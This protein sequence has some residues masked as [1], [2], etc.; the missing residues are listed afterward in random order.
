MSVSNG[1]TNENIVL[2]P[3]LS[4]IENHTI[5]MKNVGYNGDFIKIEDNVTNAILSGLK[6]VTFI[7]LISYKHLI[8]KG[9]MSGCYLGFAT[10][11]T[12]IA[13]L[14]GWSK[15]SSALLFPIGFVILVLLGNE[16]IT[17]NFALVPMTYLSNKFNNIKLL[18]INWIIVYFMNMF[19]CLIFALIYY[20]SDTL[21]GAI[22]TDIN[23]DNYK[24]LLCLTSNNKTIIY[25][26][27]NANGFFGC[28]CRGI[29]CNWM[30]TTAVMMSFTS[31]STI[32]KI[33]AMWLPIFTFVAL[34][35]EHVV[36]NFYILIEALLYN[37]NDITFG[38][39]LLWNWIPVTIG[40]IIGG[41]LFT[42][43]VY[44]YLYGKSNKP[45]L[46]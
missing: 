42:G 4:R 29:L 33:V 5:P 36:V 16:L 13:Q 32:G 38:I 30:V 24:Q 7:G 43:L 15:V 23:G 41:I 46:T 34:G 19:G 10:A 27:N 28:L 14:N 35:L 1:H 9:I 2:N 12:L 8:I 39:I 17:G 11:L 44:W 22:N 20:A 21:F 40:N 18:F 45:T 3:G 25:K 37:C 6:K 26:D 31:K